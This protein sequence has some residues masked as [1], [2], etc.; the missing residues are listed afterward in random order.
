MKIMIDYKK[1]K[2]QMM[3]TYSNITER[4]SVE[5]NKVNC[6]DNTNVLKLK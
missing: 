3:E 5:L 6:N 2:N 1:V 4:D